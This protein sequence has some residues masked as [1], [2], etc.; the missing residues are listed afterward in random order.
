M[1]EIYVKKQELL[2][3][4]GTTVSS[5]QEWRKAGSPAPQGKGKASKWPLYAICEWILN[6]PAHG[7]QN[8]ATIER[9]ASI[10]RG[11]DGVHLPDTVEIIPIDDDDGEGLEAALGRLRQAEKATFT[12][13][14][15]LF[16]IDDA[17]APQAFKD[18]QQA[19]D[20]LRKSEKS[21][22]EH[23]VQQRDLLPAAEVKEWMVTMLTTARQTMLNM[24][25]KLAPQLEGLPW[26]QI[27]KRL[28]EEVRDVL[29]KV[30]SQPCGG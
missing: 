13:W 23:L 19:L 14:Q 22:T 18:W 1:N 7:L 21:L 24:P 30:S 3:K 16:N 15:N 6:R 20:L 2:E 25:G 28:D 26:P 17:T 11:R 5:L 4:L 8:R 27:Q 12:K 10:L 29:E 9:A